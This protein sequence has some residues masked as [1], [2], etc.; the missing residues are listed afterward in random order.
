[1]YL[2]NILQAYDQSITYLNKDFFIHPLIELGLFSNAILK[3]IKPLYRVSE[4]RNHWFNTYHLHYHEKL[5]I[6]QSTYDPC[7][8]YTKNSSSCGFG[9]VGLQTDNI[10]FLADQIFVVKEEEQLYKANLLAKKRKKLDNE[11]IKFNNSY[12]KRKS[13][14]IYLT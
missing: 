4:T 12:I 9:I 2:C 10:L 11:I 14:V 5:L 8:L 13:N 3:I 7:L 1:M 6:T